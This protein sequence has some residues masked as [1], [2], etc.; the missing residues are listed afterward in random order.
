MRRTRRTFTLRVDLESDKGIRK[1]IPKLL[2]LLEK[3]GIKASFYLVM[4]GESNIFEILKYNQKMTSSAERSIKVWS[5]LDKLRIALLPIDFVKANKKVLQRILDEGHELGVHG[6]KHREWTR[7]LDKI[8]VRDRINRSIVKYNRLFNKNPIS[9]ASPG[10][11]INDK[12]LDI[13][14]ESGIKFISDFEGNKPELY[15]GVKNI[16][17]TICGDKRT[18]II[19]WLVS[20]GKTDEE[21]LNNIKSEA[22]KKELISFYIHDLFEARFKLDL[23]EKIF[24]FIRERKIESKRVVDY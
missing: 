3:Y 21:V 9:F 4:G 2:D 12:V 6:W 1:G 10:F 7:G 23:L 14:K 16:P 22:E 17:I 20:Q 19:E 24:G 18:P 5:L 13:L 8:D 15:H 11:N